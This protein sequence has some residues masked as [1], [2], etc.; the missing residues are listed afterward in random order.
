MTAE[1]AYNTD[2]HGDFSPEYTALIYCRVSSRRQANEGSG[3]DSQ[4]HRCRQYALMNGYLIEKVFLESVSGGLSIDDRPAL[5]KLL[6]YL[7]KQADK[8]KNY[9][10]IFDDHKRFARHTEMHLRLRREMEQRGVKVE[11]LNFKTDDTPES[12]FSETIFAAQAQ[13]E[14]EQNAKQNRSRVTARLEKGFWT[15]AAPI[16]YKYVKSKQ[17]SGKELV[18]DEPY[19]S[20]LQEALEGYASGRFST[21]AEVKRFLEADPHYPKDTKRGEIRLQTVARIMDQ[22]LYAGYLKADTHGVSLR[23]AQHSGLITLETYDKIQKKRVENGYMPARKDIHL[24]FVLRGA[25]HCACC[26][27]PLRSSWSTGKTKKYPYYLCQN[28]ECEAYGKSV[29][30]DK[31]EGAFAEMLNGVQPSPAV[32]AMVKAMVKDAWDAQAAKAKEATAVFKTQ[33]RETE[34]EIDELVKRVMEANSARVISAYEQRIDDLEKKKLILAEKASKTK[35]PKHSFEKIL[36]LPLLILK[37]PRK[38]W[39]SGSFEVKRTLLKL[40]FPAPIYY[41]RNEAA[42]TPLKAPHHK[43]FEALFGVFEESGAPERIRT[44][45]PL[46]RRQL[47]YP[48]EL[49]ALMEEGIWRYYSRRRRRRKGKPLM[50]RRFSL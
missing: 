44:P 30:R 9:V 5:Q 26:K 40:A 41:D 35:G 47:L 7:D 23:K 12:R 37:N 2:I 20:V 25:V 31:L 14:R 33:A 29:A 1:H 16:G 38:L 50:F 45:D 28:K 32:F 15:F 34:K 27:K 21:P 39:D 36:E 46:L 22:V 10:V 11:Y 19:A 8:D 13:L 49:R 17:G 3:L 43:G 48:T 6:A 18:R 24:D 4:E 42:R